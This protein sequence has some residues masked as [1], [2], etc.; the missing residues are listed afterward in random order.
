MPYGRILFDVAVYVDGDGNR[1]SA[2]KGQV[3][4]LPDNEYARLEGLG[5]LEKAAKGDADAD[6]ATMVKRQLVSTQ[7]PATGVITVTDPDTGEVVLS[8]AD[9]KPA[10]STPAAESK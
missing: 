3:V 1:T 4:E 8:S 9:V 5:A 2:T 6:P 7:D 10:K